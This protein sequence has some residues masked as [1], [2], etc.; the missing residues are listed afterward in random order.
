MLARGGVGLICFV[1]LLW[2][3]AAGLGAQEDVRALAREV[4]SD[5]GYQKSLPATPESSPRPA[6]PTASR[7]DEPRPDRRGS[8]LPANP[9]RREARP[10][11]PVE[12][13]DGSFL[14]ILLLL[15]AAL[16]LAFA[17]MGVIASIRERRERA[18]KVEPGPPV[19]TLPDGEPPPSPFEELA[20]AGDFSAAVHVMLQLFVADRAAASGQA[21]AR[22]A[23]GRELLRKLPRDDDERNGL[24]RLVAAV[25]LSLFG[26]RAVSENA[27]RSCLEAYRGLV[28]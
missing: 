6:S 23:T 4:L 1:S 20:A 21:V 9:R 5:P 7:S 3:A 13:A 18:R 8:S 27:Y 25:E 17:V 26:G 22:S 14:R 11:P 16:I 15:T 12:R 2:L 28:A 10:A 24:K 19:A